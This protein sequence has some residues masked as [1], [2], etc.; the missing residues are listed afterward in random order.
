MVGPN[1]SIF[2]G[3]ASGSQNPHMPHVVHPAWN[4]ASYR[5]E[6]GGPPKPFRIP[7]SAPSFNMYYCLSQND[8]LWTAKIIFQNTALPLLCHVPGQHIAEPWF[9]IELHRDG[10]DVRH[11]DITVHWPDHSS[12]GIMGHQHVCY[13]VPM[14]DW[15]QQHEIN[16]SVGRCEVSH[17]SYVM[18]LLEMELRISLRHIVVHT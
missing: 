7:L 17:L 10:Y 13:I 14:I 18:D 5:Q 2:D 11:V 1:P 3:W 8:S 4:P 16:H 6:A 15:S 12:D 9:E